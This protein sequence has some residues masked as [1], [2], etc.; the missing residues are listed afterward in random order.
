MVK[1]SWLEVLHR[2]PFSLSLFDQFT[3]AHYVPYI[4]FY[5]KPDDSR[6]GNTAQ[7]LAT[8][9]ESLMK[10]LDQFY[11]L[12]GR[13]I[14][15]LCVGCYDKGVPY[16]E[17]RSN[18]RLADVVAL[19]EIEL[20]NQLFPCQCFCSVPT[21]TSPQMAVQVTVFGRG[22]DGEIRDP[23]MFYAASRL[24]PPSESIP[25]DILS[26]IETVRF[27][28][29][30]HTTKT[31]LVHDDAIATLK[32]KAKSKRLEH[33]T[34]NVAL[35]AFLWK[36]AMLATRAASGRSRPSVLI[37][38]VNLRPILNLP[39][40]AIGNLVWF[41]IST[42]N[43]S[44]TAADIELDHLA[45]LVREALDVSKDQITLLQSGD[46][47]KVLTE[48]YKKV[49]DFASQVD[50]DFFASTSWLNTRRRRPKFR[51]GT[52]DVFRHR[53]ERDSLLFI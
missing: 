48:E 33:P 3:P 21:S 12:Y 8:V 31:F 38:S 18:A 28:E 5:N 44:A 39:E 11:T 23:D 9:R 52:A 27:P 46:V 6:F 7:I 20:L 36:H 29:G 13:P 10:A 26:F 41:A 50:V 37:Q 15:N 43:P 17:A 49:E 53:V 47:L 1:P 40:H 25:R 24:F 19:T 14:D 22:S 30:W 42:Y 34:R 45:Y 4:L 35:T 51:M 2:K 16:V 32:L